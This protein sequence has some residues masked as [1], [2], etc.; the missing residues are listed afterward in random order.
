L[1]NAFFW[2]LLTN[3]LGIAVNF[4]SVVLLARM[5]TPG[6]IGTYA[7]A[8][9]IFSIAQIFRDMGI[10]GYLLR[11]KK[12]TETALSGA[13]TIVWA[14]CSTISLSLLLASPALANFYSIPELTA[15]FQIL[16]LNIFLIPCGTI[17]QTFLRREMNFKTLGGIELSS[18]IV[19]LIVALTLA[20]Y[21]F[22][23]LS[24]AYAS[25][26]ATLTTIFLV[27]AAH[28]GR[29]QF[30]IS[31]SNAKQVLPNVSVIG[32]ANILSTLNSR[33]TPLI[34]GK[35]LS[36]NAVAMMDKALATIELLN[37]LLMQ[38][39]QKVLLPY[40]TKI[41][42][43][44]DDI[45]EAYLLV[46][47]YTLLFA[48]PF[49]F[50]IS[51]LSEF[52]VITLFGDQWKA[53]IPLVP[54][55]AVASAFGMVVRYFGEVTISIGLEKVL[56][57]VN[58]SVFCIKVFILLIFSAYGLEAIAYSLLV[59]SILRTSYILY[60]IKR[61]LNIGLMVFSKNVSKT[62][63]VSVISVFPYFIGS[64]YGVNFAEVPE[65]IILFVTVVIFWLTSIFI[66][67]HKARH[68]IS[69]LLKPIVNRYLLRKE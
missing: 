9:A 7:I 22:G 5:L 39:I 38:A 40:F 24:L 47:N 67:N 33:V 21:N 19:H 65:V 66:V 12:L 52:V 34:V 36:Q 17:A 63:I 13:M 57:K 20:Y 58:F 10:S 16:C 29:K 15:I 18:Q 27:N 23:A 25:L 51:A 69:I 35:Y 46:T 43:K 26:S 37:Q 45:S 4:V 30:A 32:F 1:K 28:K 62:I 2:S 55:F 59:V 44:T 56:M 11:E 53:A 48:L 68:D 54:I 41:R 49:L 61:T 8:G 6:E 31:L 64:F 3:Y 50:Y 42:E 60:L 14:L